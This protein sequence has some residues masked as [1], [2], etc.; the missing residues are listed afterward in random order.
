MKTEFLIFGLT[1]ILCLSACATEDV[2]YYPDVDPI[3]TWKVNVSSDSV[4]QLAAGQYA[5]SP[6]VIGDSNLV[7]AS[8]YNEA[9]NSNGILYSSLG[10]SDAK[11]VVS[12]GESGAWDET[13]VSNPSVVGGKFLYEGILYTYAM[14]YQGR[15]QGQD[16]TSI[17]VAFCNNL[18]GNEWV[19]YSTPIV[20][21]ASSPSAICI[22]RRG[23]VLLTYTVSDLT[24]T[25]SDWRIMNLNDMS[26]P[27]FGT[28]SSVHTTDLVDI[29]SEGQDFVAEADL[30]IDEAADKIVMIRP[31]HPLP[32]TYPTFL[33]E[34]LEICYMN[35]SNFL[36]GKGWWVPMARVNVQTS[37]YSRNHG[38]SLVRDEYGYISN[39]RQ[40]EIYFTVGKAEP[41]IS[42][43]TTP[44]QT[45]FEIRKAVVAIVD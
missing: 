9:G 11:Q 7:L 19:K 28:A 24:G 12:L 32:T 45:T 18:S 15:A 39:Y 31:V 13:E 36:E 44:C 8:L 6:T 37:G 33:S 43:L 23:R 10:K 1:S 42:A 21:S 16:D 14:F 29:S 26:A 35:F 41:D 2:I 27:S 20:E 38:A 17:G 4:L 3:P 40:P 22:D 5:S 25:R 30:A 34:E